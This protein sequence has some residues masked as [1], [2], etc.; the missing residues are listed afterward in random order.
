[1]FRR[2]GYALDYLDGFVGQI[3]RSVCSDAGGLA[4]QPRN[5]ANR[6]F[7]HITTTV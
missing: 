6:S 2:S 5:A 1:L 7:R 3:F 4:L